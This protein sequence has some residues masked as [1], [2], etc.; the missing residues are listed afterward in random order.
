MVT[1][2]RQQVPRPPGA[3]RVAP[4]AR[5]AAMGADEAAEALSLGH[6]RRVFPGEGGGLGAVAGLEH[7]EH[8]VAAAVLVA[9]VDASSGG[10]AVTLIRRAAHMRANPG[11]IAFPGG[12]LEPGETPAQA[13]VRE[14]FE[15][16]RLPAEAV[17]LRGT[18][19]P[20]ARASRP[21]GIVP[22]VAEV[23]GAP[24]LEA[25][26]A[27]VDA[28]LVTPLAELA[29]PGRYWEELWVRPDRRVWRM[30]FFDLGEDL[31]WGASARILVSFLERLAAHR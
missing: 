3:Q 24:R 15:E 29:D 11:E 31:C 8:K 20:V 9:L 26:P 14:A 5:F 27:E 12:R 21:E 17:V 7:G 16:V 2:F 19:P 1:S 30:S 23:A 28:V 13:A 18:L 6:I 4:Q 22:V 10:P 25:N